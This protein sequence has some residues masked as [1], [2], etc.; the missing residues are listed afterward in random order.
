MPRSAQEWSR[1]PKSAQKCLRVLN[2]AFKGFCDIQTEK[3]FWVRISPLGLKKRLIFIQS[4]TKALS[5]LLTTFILQDSSSTMSPFPISLLLLFWLW[6][7]SLHLSP[8]LS[9]T[10]DL[11]Y[12]WDAKKGC[13]KI[14]KI[15]ASELGSKSGLMRGFQKGITL[16][17]RTFGS[18]WKV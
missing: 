9:L 4:Y 5:C 7:L 16:G 6:I 1:V 18:V 14:S 17:S 3:W 11:T 10:W 12:F 15:F 2:R 13:K 8:P